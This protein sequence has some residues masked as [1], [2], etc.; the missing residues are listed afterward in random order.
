VANARCSAFTW[1]PLSPGFSVVPGAPVAGLVVAVVVDV[2]GSVAVLE[3]SI[4]GRGELLLKT[5][6]AAS[7]AIRKAK[8]TGWNEYA[9]L[10]EAT[11]LD[12]ERRRR[13]RVV[14]IERFIL[15]GYPGP[16]RRWRCVGLGEP[17]VPRALGHL[18]EK[19]SGLAVDMAQR[20]KR[21]S[22]EDDRGRP[23]YYL[24]MLIARAAT[25]SASTRLAAASTS[26]SIFAQRLNGI[27]SVGLKAVAFVNEM[28]R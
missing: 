10:D 17:V 12:R 2:V 1:T 20:V 4:V 25:M 9:P 26:M 5:P 18:H 7:A 23:R 3:V 16:A 22:A 11:Q 15:G 27:V 19:R 28:Y 13:P 24:R 8:A 6:A 14:V 21:T